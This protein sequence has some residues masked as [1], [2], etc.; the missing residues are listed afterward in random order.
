M[1][2]LLLGMNISCLFYFQLQDLPSSS[3]TVEEIVIEVLKSQGE[4]GFCEP[5]LVNHS[6]Q[7]VTSATS[8]I[9]ENPWD[10]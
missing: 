9:S 2:E 1:L 6:T 3:G 7:E 8:F 5:E 10:I 4:K